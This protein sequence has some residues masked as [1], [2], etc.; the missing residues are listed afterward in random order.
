MPYQRRFSTKSPEAKDDRSHAMRHGI[1]LSRCVGLATRPCLADRIERW[2]V[3]P[4][5]LSGRPCDR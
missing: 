2:N 3:S 4:H 1:D 5:R